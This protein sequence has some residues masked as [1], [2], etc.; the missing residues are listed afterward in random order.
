MRALLQTS[1]LLMVYIQT[2][3]YGEMPIHL[4][5][6][7]GCHG[8]ALAGQFGFFVFGVGR[9]NEDEQVPIIWRD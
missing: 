9:L 8:S 4:T 1:D 2:V 3:N 6:V 7:Y 5:I